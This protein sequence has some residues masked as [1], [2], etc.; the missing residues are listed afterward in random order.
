MSFLTVDYSYLAAQHRGG[1]LFLPYLPGN[2]LP[3]DPQPPAGYGADYLI[4]FPGESATPYATLQAALDVAVLNGLSYGFPIFPFDAGTFYYGFYTDTNPLPSY[5][6][7][8]ATLDD[9]PQYVYLLFGP[10]AIDVIVNSSES[11]AC[12]ILF[13]SGAAA[14]PTADAATVYAAPNVIYI[15][16][17]P[18]VSFIFVYETSGGSPSFPCNIN[19]CI[20]YPGQPDGYFPTVIAAP[21]TIIRAE[22]L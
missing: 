8:G 12:T 15:N 3:P 11:Q 20:N 22:K 16:N 7:G 5:F 18:L 10:R 21:L 14:S 9:E 13:D 2:P 17:P 6:A 1:N 19:N 4:R